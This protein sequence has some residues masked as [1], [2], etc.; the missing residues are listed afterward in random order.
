MAAHSTAPPEMK[1]PSVAATIKAKTIHEKTIFMV[2]AKKEDGSIE[3]RRERKG[4]KSITKTSGRRRS[5]G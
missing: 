5:K 1:A 2:N 3:A 4:R